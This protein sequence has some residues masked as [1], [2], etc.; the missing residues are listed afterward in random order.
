MLRAYGSR[1]TT[2]SV[3]AAIAYTEHTSYCCCNQYEGSVDPWSDAWI[4]VNAW[5]CSRARFHFGN[6]T[7]WRGGL[8]ER[9]GGA[10]R[11]VQH[12]VWLSG[13]LC[14]WNKPDGMK[15]DRRSRQLKTLKQNT[16]GHPGWSIDTPRISLDFI[17]PGGIG[18][19]ARYRDCG[20][21]CAKLDGALQGVG[22]NVR[23]C[24]LA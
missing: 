19:G 14:V 8:F 20:D 6:A 11:G 3:E 17:G 15:E 12:A 2:R 7:A 18:T 24:G 22:R 21:F 16:Q 10:L 1:L 4:S 23:Y 13:C 5:L 9:P